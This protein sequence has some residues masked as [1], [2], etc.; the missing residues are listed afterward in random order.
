MVSA[1]RADL[2]SWALCGMAG[3]PEKD[4][5]IYACYAADQ[6]DSA[7]PPQGYDWPARMR[8]RHRM[9]PL[10]FAGHDLAALPDG[11]LYWP[12]RR[13]LILA[14]LHFGKACWFAQAGQM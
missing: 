7:A 8:Q 12:A 2:G 3:R 6:A 5:A 1:M 9:V 14:A 4:G 13:A 11:A 10:S